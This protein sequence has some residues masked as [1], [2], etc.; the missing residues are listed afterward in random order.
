M[1]KIF[2]FAVLIY[3]TASNAQKDF[4]GMIRYKATSSYERMK[5]DDEKPDTTEIKVFFAPGRLLTIA[6]KEDDAETTLTILDSAKS[7][8]LNKEK[9]SYRE[10]KL[11]Q[12]M[13]AVF[14]EKENIQGYSTTS[15]QAQSYLLSALPG[16]VYYW[17]ADS[18]YFHIPPGLEKNEELVM[19]VENRILLKVVANLSITSSRTVNDSVIH[20]NEF[21]SD[22]TLTAV[23]IKPGKINPEIFA[24][25]AGYTRQDI[26]DNNEIIIG[27]TDTASLA[28][29]TPP[30]AKKPVQKTPTKKPVT[31]TSQ[32]PPAKKQE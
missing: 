11:F 32:K 14:P 21:S 4:E 15:I 5:N 22:I 6:D 2:L 30:P 26:S 20:S 29:P 23:E 3:A 31:T 18:L 1:K 7:Y 9:K 17:L 19:I 10:K 28:A 24:I 25:P 16:A 8:I 13:P 27:A 12:I